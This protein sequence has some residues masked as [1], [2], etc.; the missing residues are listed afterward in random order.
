MKEKIILTNQRVGMYLYGVLE[1][2][3]KS[4]LVFGPWS[5]NKARRM[6]KI[7]FYAVHIGKV[8]QITERI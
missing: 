6:S 4:F 5:F 3:L 8:S 1:V 7:Y 2:N